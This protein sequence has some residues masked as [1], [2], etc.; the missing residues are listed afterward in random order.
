V[1]FINANKKGI[2]VV[3]MEYRKQIARKYIFVANVFGVGGYFVICV[4]FDT[5][6]RYT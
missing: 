1:I 6:K 5:F 2:K 4:I 3:D